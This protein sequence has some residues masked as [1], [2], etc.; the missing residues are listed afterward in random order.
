MDPAQ[1]H[2]ILRSFD[3]AVTYAK[4]PPDPF[5]K[6]TEVGIG[7]VLIATSSIA[8]VTETDKT[9]LV[10]TTDGRRYLVQETFDEI[11]QRLG[12]LLVERRDT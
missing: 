1:I 11:A 12:S 6:I 5:V 8:S 3:H 4:L 9:V 2:H 7:R 10:Y